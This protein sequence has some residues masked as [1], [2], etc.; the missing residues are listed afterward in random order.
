M[1]KSAESVYNG[2][3]EGGRN[4]NPEVK[5]PQNVQ[6]LIK[7]IGEKL[8]LFRLFLLVKNT[9]WEVYQNYSE[10]GCDLILLN[11]LMNRK[12]KIEV[13]TR[14]R[15]YTTSKKKAKRVQFTLTANEYDNCDFLIGY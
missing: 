10:P 14:Q 9:N 15:L 2:K 11:S 6:N 8:V 5:L 12:I 4:I 7:E 1:K 3:L 13:K